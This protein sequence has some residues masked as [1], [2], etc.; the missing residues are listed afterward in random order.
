MWCGLVGITLPTMG[1]LQT[2]VSQFRTTL[3]FMKPIQI[4]V[5]SF[6]IT[7]YLIYKLPITGTLPIALNWITLSLATLSHSRWSLTFIRAEE[8]KAKSSMF[9]YFCSG[10]ERINYCLL[11]LCRVSAPRPTRARRGTLNSSSSI[12]S[13][14]DPS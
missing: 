3:P 11:F 7:G 13:T 2:L 14:I 10:V 1:L 8:A 6:G 9:Q 5:L 4:I 12:P